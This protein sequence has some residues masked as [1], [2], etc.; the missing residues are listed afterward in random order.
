MYRA[1]L[2]L[3]GFDNECRQHIAENLEKRG[4]Q[5]RLTL[6]IAEHVEKRGIQ[7]RLTCTCVLAVRV[8]VR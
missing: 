7:V 5:V 6:Y 1:D 8:T 4:I 3:R 2:P